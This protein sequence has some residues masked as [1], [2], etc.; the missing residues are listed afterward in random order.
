MRV[1]ALLKADASV[2]LRQAPTVH[3]QGRTAA[4]VLAVLADRDIGTAVTDAL[5]RDFAAIRPRKRGV[6]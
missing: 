5:E 3:R 1:I 2:L 6:C 4:N